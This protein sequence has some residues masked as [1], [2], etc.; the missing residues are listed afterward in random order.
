MMIAHEFCM[1]VLAV[2]RSGIPVHVK[3][4]SLPNSLDHWTWKLCVDEYHNLL[5]AVRSQLSSR[6]SV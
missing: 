5:I 2:Y 4:R 1:L 6:D 3:Q